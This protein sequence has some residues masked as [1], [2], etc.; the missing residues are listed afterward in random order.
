[1]TDYLIQALR[2]TLFYT[3]RTW[4]SF[5]KRPTR[6]N[7]GL[8]QKAHSLQLERMTSAIINSEF[9]SAPTISL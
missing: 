3:N 4:Q 1:M 5:S 6:P 8:H 7:A 2:L 9:L